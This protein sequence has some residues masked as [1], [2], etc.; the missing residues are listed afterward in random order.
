MPSKDGLSTPGLS[1][2]L[3]YMAGTVLST[4]GR[5]ALSKRQS[6][7]PAFTELTAKQRPSAAG[8]TMQGDAC[9]LKGVHSSYIEGDFDPVLGN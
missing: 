7:S 1:T 9:Q 5:S 6:G 8:Q 4:G 3:C 2:E